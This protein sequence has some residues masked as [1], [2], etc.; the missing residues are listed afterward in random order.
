MSSRDPASQSAE[1]TEIREAWET[2]RSDWEARVEQLQRQ[3]EQQRESLADELRGEVRGEVQEEIQATQAALQAER[4]QLE[5]EL[6]KTVAE[7]AE[8]QKYVTA[9]VTQRQVMANLNRLHREKK[10]II[11][12]LNPFRGD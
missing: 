11:R 7:R 5:E 10:G 6:A 3:V 9:E 4:E 2:E 1:L 8:Y 12:K